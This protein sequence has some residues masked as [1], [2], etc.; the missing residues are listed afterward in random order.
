[1]QY[2]VA[3]EPSFP[4]T[5]TLSLGEREQPAAGASFADIRVAKSVECM[6]QRWLTILPLPGGEG[7]GEG[8]KR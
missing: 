5:P 3:V 6:Y 8:K 1:M 7:R 4:L 2:S